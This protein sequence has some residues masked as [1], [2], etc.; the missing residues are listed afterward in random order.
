MHL[1][2]EIKEALLKRGYV[3]ILI[4][5]GVTG[6]IQI[7]DTDLHTP[8]KANYR[9]LEQSLMLQQLKSDPKRIPQPSRDDMM[10]MVVES[11]NSVN[12]DVES[13]FK[14]LWVTNSLDGSEYYLATQHGHLTTLITQSKHSSK[15]SPT[16]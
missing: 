7:N 3:P 4:G 16:K 2:P 8:L 11:I 1:I 10:K 13:R 14:A 6:D 5:G 12:L 15:P 9:E